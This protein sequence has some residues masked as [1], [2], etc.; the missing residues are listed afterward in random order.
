MFKFVGIFLRIH[1]IKFHRLYLGRHLVETVDVDA[2]AIKIG[3]RYIKRLNATGLA[4]KV[5][6]F[7]AVE[8]VSR[9]IF[10]SLKKGKTVGSVLSDADSLT[11]SIPSSCTFPVPR[12]IPPLPE[13]AP[14]HNGS[15]Q[16]Q[17]PR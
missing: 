14:H 17:S 4:K 16:W 11:W 1:S 7:F 3:T 10:F 13:N 9:Q 2:H 5:L 6:G 8:S 15:R 12:E